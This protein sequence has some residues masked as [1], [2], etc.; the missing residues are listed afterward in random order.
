MIPQLRCPATFTA[1]SGAFI[2]SFRL[3]SV[4]KPA[5]LLT[6]RSCSL[7]WEWN[8]WAPWKEIIKTLVRYPQ[9]KVTCLLD[10]LIAYL[11]LVVAV[12]MKS[13]SSLSFSPK[14]SHFAVIYG[15]SWYQFFR[16]CSRTPAAPVSW[17]NRA[18]PNINVWLTIH[19]RCF[20]ITIFEP[21]WC[22]NKF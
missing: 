8:V 5:K 11:S 6:W 10:K 12:K 15:G 1:W 16:V 13:L 18:P 9:V 14:P 22:L 7:T 2:F 19:E 17:K 20:I 4:L 21:Y 3:P